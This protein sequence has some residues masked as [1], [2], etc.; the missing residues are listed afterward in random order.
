[1]NLD[2]IRSDVGKDCFRRDHAARPDAAKGECCRNDRAKPPKCVPPSPPR[3]RT[4][5]KL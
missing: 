1:M 2:K 4:Q 5:G 3:A